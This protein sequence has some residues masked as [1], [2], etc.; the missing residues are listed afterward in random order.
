MRGE[1]PTAMETTETILSTVVYIVVNIR[2]ILNS[3]II[4]MTQTIA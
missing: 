4:Q 1:N 3:Y 2:T